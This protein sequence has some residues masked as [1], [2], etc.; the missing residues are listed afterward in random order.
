MQATSTGLPT[1]ALSHF[2]ETHLD[3]VVSADS[4]CQTYSMRLVLT[5]RMGSGFGRRRPILCVWI[6]GNLHHE[7]PI[8]SRV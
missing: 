7:A 4:A 1:L 5:T 6:V 3:L 8:P 2:Q